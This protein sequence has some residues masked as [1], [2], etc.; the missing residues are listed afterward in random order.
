MKLTSDYTRIAS[1]NEENTPEQE[2]EFR[3]RDW[4]EVTKIPPNLNHLGWRLEDNSWTASGGGYDSG[5]R[6]IA[7]KDTSEN[8]ADARVKYTIWAERKLHEDWRGDYYEYYFNSLY[9]IIPARKTRKNVE[10]HTLESGDTL[11]EVM[12][13]CEKHYK[14]EFGVS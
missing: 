10:T 3:S 12:L 6:W 2:E 11:A 7:E 13:A 14:E 1:F 4:P 8:P 5:P 9:K